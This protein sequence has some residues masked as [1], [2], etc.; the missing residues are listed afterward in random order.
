M[1]PNKHTDQ[2]RLRA[3]QIGSRHRNLTLM[4]VFLFQSIARQEAMI[5]PIRA[6]L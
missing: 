2:R 6:L 5:V 1:Q 3:P 4:Q